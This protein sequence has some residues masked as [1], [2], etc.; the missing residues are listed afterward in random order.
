MLNLAK[1]RSYKIFHLLSVE[2]LKFEPIQVHDRRDEVKVGA[3]LVYEGIIDWEIE[4]APLH[5]I[6]LFQRI[7]D[8]FV[9]LSVSI[10]VPRFEVPIHSSAFL[11]LNR[12]C[13]AHL[14]VG[15]YD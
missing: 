1:Q 2:N 13:E 15:V 12:E 4:V 14:R 9:L 5:S 11:E 3:H 10:F 7:Q 8:R 6:V